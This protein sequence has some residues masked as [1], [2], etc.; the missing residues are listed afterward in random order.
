MFDLIN[1]FDWVFR[2]FFEF[3]AFLLSLQKHTH[4]EKLNNTFEK[5]LYNSFYLLMIAP[6]KVN[7]ISSKGLRIKFYLK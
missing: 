1:E 4:V 6:D 7:N 5:I 3:K 2:S